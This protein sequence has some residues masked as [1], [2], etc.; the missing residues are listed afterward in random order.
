GSRAVAAS[1]NGGPSRSRARPAQCTERQ[2]P[3]PGTEAP[4]SHLSVEPPADLP[5]LA[6]DLGEVAE[7]LLPIGIDGGVQLLQFHPHPVAARL[8][9]ELVEALTDAFGVLGRW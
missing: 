2:G 6:V 4:S 7:E 1:L 3:R 8:E 5:E 9:Q